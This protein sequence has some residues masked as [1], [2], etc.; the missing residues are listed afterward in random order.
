M[1]AKKKKVKSEH[2]GKE[3]FDFVNGIFADQRMA[4]FDDLSEEEK[5]K[6]H[7]S[8][9]MIHR[10]ISMNAHYIPIANAVQKYTE[11]PARNHYQFLTRMLP[12][13]RQFNK[14]IKGSKESKYEQWMV[15]LVANHFNVRKSEAM[16]YID[17][18]QQ[19]NIDELVTICR[20]YGTDMK[21]IQHALN[22]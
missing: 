19:H 12:K 6:Y 3:L 18:Y 1:A 2:K 15:E 4:F 11:L 8:R 20:M 13:G 14:Y 5:K 10:F 7:Q 21:D 16:T 17:L 9:W 22:I